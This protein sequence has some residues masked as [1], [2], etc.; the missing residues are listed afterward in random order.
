[1]NIKNRVGLSIFTSFIYIILIETF[2]IINASS[3]TFKYTLSFI[4]NLLIKY[5]CI[6]TITSL[7]YFVFSYVLYPIFKRVRN[8]KVYFIIS[9]I[10][11]LI[12]N[13]FLLYFKLLPEIGLL[14]SE[15][16]F[17]FIIIFTTTIYF[18][19]ITYY[20]LLK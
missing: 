6:F 16:S 4:D 2:Y 12:H 11:Y 14:S 9:G 7:F 18:Y 19:S 17:F 20:N 1:M 13:I 10:N 5:I 8:I 15:I 3:F